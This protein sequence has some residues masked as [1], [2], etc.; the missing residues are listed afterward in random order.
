MTTLLKRVKSKLYIAS[1]RKSLHALEGEYVSAMRG[2]SM[3]FDDLREYEIG[4]EIKDIDWKASAR[5]ATPLVKQ[6]IA[7]R[8]Q[9]ILFVVDSG[10]NMSAV[11]AAGE[12]KKNIIISIVGT[13]GFLAIKHSDSVGLI[14]A[15]AEA[16][17]HIPQRETETHLE[18]ILQNINNNISYES[19][20]SNLFSQLDYLYKNVKTRNLVVVIT[21]EAKRTQET[22]FLLKRLRVKHEVL[23]IIIGD[24]NPL[25]QD[26]AKDIIVRDINDDTDIPDFMRLNKTLVNKYAQREKDYRTDTNLYFRDLNISHIFISSEKEVVSRMLQLLQRRFRGKR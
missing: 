24:G 14:M 5:S 11:S 7:T 6:Y 15:N 16:K 26:S 4:D 9:P 25:A 23:W 1:Y 22:D 2:R 18:R 19:P 20:K 21:D 17:H 12:E 8:K 10:R 3:D 13:L